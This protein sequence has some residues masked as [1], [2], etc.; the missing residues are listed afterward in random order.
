MNTTKE[1]CALLHKAIGCLIEADIKLNGVGDYLI[2]FSKVKK[3]I[4]EDLAYFEKPEREA[5]VDEFIEFMEAETREE[6]SDYELDELLEERLN[7]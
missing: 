7:K 1:V 4:D 5:Q 3:L 6:M 2:N